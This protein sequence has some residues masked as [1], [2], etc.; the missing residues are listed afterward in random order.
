MKRP[1]LA[2]WLLCDH[3]TYWL[4]HYSVPV[5]GSLW[6]TSSLLYVTWLLWSWVAILPTILQLQV[7]DKPYY[8]SSDFHSFVKGTTIGKIFYIV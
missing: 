7:V 3:D 4:T 6:P 8:N 1:E 5:A 2:A